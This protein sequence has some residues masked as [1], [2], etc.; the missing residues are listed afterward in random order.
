VNVVIASGRGLRTTA[1]LRFSAA[2]TMEDWISSMF[3]SV[4]YLNGFVTHVI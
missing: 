1:I 4:S 2:V 3:R